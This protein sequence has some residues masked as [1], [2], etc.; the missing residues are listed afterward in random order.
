M[1]CA[2]AWASI[3]R[4]EGFLLAEERH[5]ATEYLEGM[6]SALTSM[7]DIKA[8][9]QLESG[10]P[11][12]TF[13]NASIGMKGTSYLQ[14]LTSDCPAGQLTMVTGSVASVSQTKQNPCLAKKHV[15]QKQLLASHPWRIRCHLWLDRL[16]GRL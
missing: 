3:A 9:K 16:L 12:V 15:G 10:P 2:G 11:Q 1:T 5:Q 13:R 8:E 4:I 6:K 14:N 7:Y